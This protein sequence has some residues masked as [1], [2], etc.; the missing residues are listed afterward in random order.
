MSLPA[1]IPR[2]RWFGTERVRTSI[3][4]HSNPLS[5]PLAKAPTLPT[6]AK[7]ARQMRS[8]ASTSYTRLLP[9]I[10][11]NA[12]KGEKSGRRAS[13]A[14]PQTT[15]LSTADLGATESRS[16]SMDLYLFAILCY[17]SWSKQTR[18]S[19]ALLQINT[20]QVHTVQTKMLQA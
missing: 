7:R 14:H 15:P 9:Q 17:E 10:S 2:P 4:F 12:D 11:N 19:R 13:L 16:S 5:R 18:V 6:E 3:R 8:C 1:V 20:C